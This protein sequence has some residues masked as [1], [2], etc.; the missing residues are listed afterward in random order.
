RLGCLLVNPDGDA[1]RVDARAL[2]PPGLEASCVW[3]LA[4]ALWANDRACPQLRTFDLGHRQLL[5]LVG[6]NIAL[7]GAKPVQLGM[8]GLGRMGANMVRRLLR[9]GHQCV[10][11]DVNP[12]N[13]EEVVRDSATGATSLEDFVKKLTKPRAVWIM[14]PLEYTEPTVMKFGDLLVRGDILIAAGNSYFKDDARRT[15]G[16]A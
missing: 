7:K 14:I 8:V 10:A 16:L 15:K 11:F 3:D 12:K 9:G 5:S 2:S 4:A 13:V 6:L 1:V